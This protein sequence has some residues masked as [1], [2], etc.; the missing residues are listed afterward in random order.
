M[1]DSPEEDRHFS[2]PA[3]FGTTFGNVLEVTVHGAQAHFYTIS[4]EQLDSLSTGHWLIYTNLASAFFGSFVS[5]VSIFLAGYSNPSPLHATIASGAAMTTG[6]LCVLFTLLAA[7]GYRAHTRNL[8][9]IKVRRP[10]F[11]P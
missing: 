11:R 4:E 5:L 3:A 6:F 9:L 7:S 10:N 2:G 8:R 1:S